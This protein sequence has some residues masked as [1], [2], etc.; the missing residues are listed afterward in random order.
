MSYKSFTSVYKLNKVKE[1]KFASTY[2]TFLCTFLVH[3]EME[4]CENSRVFARSLPDRLIY[5]SALFMHFSHTLFAIVSLTMI[6]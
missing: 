6:A 2:L 5:I 1:R 4:S 3:L